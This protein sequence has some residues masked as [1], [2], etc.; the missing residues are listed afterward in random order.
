MSEIEEIIKSTI[1]NSYASFSDLL[2]EM[3]DNPAI[4][5]MSSKDALLFIAGSIGANK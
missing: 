4:Q 3:A 1:D 5:K 2:I